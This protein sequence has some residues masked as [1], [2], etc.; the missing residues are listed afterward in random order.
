MSWIRSTLSL[1]LLRK[2]LVEQAL[3]KRTYIIRVIYA[4]LLFFAFCV[5]LSDELDR[6][7]GNPFFMLGSGKQMFEFLVGLQFAGI[8]IFLPAMVSG[9]LT[10]EKERGSLGLLFLTDL[11][12]WEILIQ[13]LLGRLVPMFSFFLLVLPLM[14]IAYAFGGISAP[15]LA[16]GIYLLFLTCFQVAAISLAASSSCRTSGRSFLISYGLILLLYFGVAVLFMILESLE[17]TRFS[18]RSEAY[19]FAFVPPYLFEDARTE[20]FADVF[21]RSIPVIASVAGFLLVAR[22]FLIRRAFV[23]AKDVVLNVFKG[24]DRFMSGLNVITGGII[25]VKDKKKLPGNEPIAWREVS[26]KSLG[27]LHYLLRFLL[28][29]EIP[30]IIFITAFAIQQA[31][32]YSWG[33]AEGITALI[34]IVWAIAILA[35]SLKSSNTIVSERASQTLE[36]LLTTPLSGREI[37]RQKMRGVR[38]VIIVL[39]IPLITAIAAEAWWESP[40][41]SIGYWGR[42]YSPRL[43]ILAYLVSSLLSVFIFLP[44]FAWVSLWIGL[45]V[46]SK[47]RA[48][49]VTLITVLGWITVPFLLVGLVHVL[50]DFYYDSAVNIFTLFSPL[51]ILV[52]TETGDFDMVGTV[53]GVAIV[54]TY[55]WH[56]ALLFYF[57][58]LCLKR[59][60]RYLGR[61]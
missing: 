23:P 52:V 29:I 43:D 6:Y 26:K 46:R 22:V 14:A 42:S 39:M 25:L 33:D 18:W 20:E 19:I 58:W 34:F 12:P 7:E 55:L 57:R 1:P 40:S 16:S 38:R 50:G 37:V 8:Y 53:P 48:I 45:K 24:L 47:S 17:L 31:G 54:L 5:Y 49:I 13:K 15:Y 51:S 3:R 41:I 36:V 11:S 21:L 60:D 35:V 4:S 44:M 28:L 32:R 56:G 10:S 27:K 61:I 59:A 30:L 2:E 9:V